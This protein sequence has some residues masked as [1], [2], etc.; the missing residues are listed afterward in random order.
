[1]I[2]DPKMQGRGFGSILLENCEKYAIVQGFKYT[3]LDAFKK[4]II[5][6]QLYII[7][8]PFPKAVSKQVDP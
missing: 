6:N 5:S 4:N 3:R 8:L 1:M 7:E 2:I